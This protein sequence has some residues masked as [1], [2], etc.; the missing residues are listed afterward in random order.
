[1]T[2]RLGLTP[3]LPLHAAMSMR[4]GFHSSC[5]TMDP[6]DSI[7]VEAPPRSS[8][9]LEQA[10]QRRRRGAHS[11]ELILIAT[12]SFVILSLLNSEF[13]VRSYSVQNVPREFDSPN[14]AAWEGGTTATDSRE[15]SR[16]SVLENH[17]RGSVHR[18]AFITFSYVR[19]NDTNKLFNFLL[20]AVDTW[21]APLH[22]DH[23][24]TFNNPNEREEFPLYVV[25]SNTSRKA[26]ED[27]CT[28]DN[29]PPQSR[30][31]CRRIHPIY[32]DCPE[33]RW[34]ES[35]CCKQQKGLVEIFGKK[36]PLYDW[37]AFFDDDVYLR[38]E[39]VATLLAELQPPDFPM[40]ASPYNQEKQPIG[41]GRK[42]CGKGMKQ[43]L[44]P[45]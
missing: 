36:Y 11:V 21:A 33:G 28:H 39:Y 14:P 30:K 7:Q 34:G 15:Q 3:P 40:A 42:T 22:D 45:W 8:S 12:I 13:I 17:P 9:Q 29:I 18:I 27:I 44:Y 23:N 35:P 6:P 31:L 32:V 2:W 5:S 19:H 41:H 16:E 10:P 38:K 37:Y 25:F 24:T 43:F 20:P 26:F 4:S 1:M